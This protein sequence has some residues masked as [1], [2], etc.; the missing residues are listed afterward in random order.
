MNHGLI[1]PSYGVLEFYKMF[2]NGTSLSLYKF[3][4]EI[5]TNHSV[6]FNTKLQFGGIALNIL[7]S[8]ISMMMLMSIRVSFLIS[9]VTTSLQSLL[10]VPSLG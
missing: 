6:I 8:L 10:R 7:F 5:N 1:E 3:L 2:K 9:K 4:P